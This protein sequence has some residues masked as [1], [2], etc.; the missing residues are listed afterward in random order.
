MASKRGN[1][2]QGRVKSP[3]K[4]HRYSFPTKA[5][6]EEWERDAREALR[7]GQP[8]PAPTVQQS[9]MHSK[10]LKLQDIYDK[11]SAAIWEDHNQRKA[12]SETKMASNYLP[13]V[14]VDQLTS[15]DLVRMVAKAKAEGKRPS[16]INSYICRVRRLINYA[17]SLGETDAHL[18][19]PSVTVGNNSRIR[20]L[21]E[22]EEA[23]LIAALDHMGLPDVARLTELLI[24]TGCRTGE[25]IHGEAKAAPVRWSE[26]SAEAGGTEAS[27]RDPKTGQMRPVMRLVRTKTDQPRTLPL[28]DRAVAAL[29]WSKAQ[30]HRSPFASLDHWMFYSRF[31]R[32]AKHIGLE[33]V[34]PYTLRHTCASRLVQRGADLRRVQAWM[35]HSNITMTLRYAKLVPTDIFELEELL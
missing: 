25:I 33:D 7:L 23:K 24:D 8:I 16:T 6:A 14:P 12:K 11:Y 20:F 26:I 31:T 1:S 2:W 9:G 18:D 35:G 19:Y 22:D 27:I 4:Y 5:A 15:S 10:R 28:T 29:T 21:S 13:D 30:G 17:N 34:I 32:V 3:D